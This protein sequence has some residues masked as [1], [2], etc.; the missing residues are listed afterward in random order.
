MPITFPFYIPKNIALSKKES[1][2]EMKIN[3]IH[4]FLSYHSKPGTVDKKQ[5]FKLPT[6]SCPRT[7]K[8][9]VEKVLLGVWI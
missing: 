2:S 1:K 4:T 3:T 5:W 8:N 9:V 6:N 7:L